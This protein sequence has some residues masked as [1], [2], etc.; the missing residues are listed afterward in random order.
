MGND[1]IRLDEDSISHMTSFLKFMPQAIPKAIARAMN[2]AISSAKTEASRTLR[3]KYTLKSSTI[4]E[5]MSLVRA[6]P[7]N[8]TAALKSSSY[9]ASLSLNRYKVNP[10]KDTT[11]SPHRSVTVEILKGK[12]FK[13]DK[14]FV[15]NGTVFRRSG[16]DRLPI[17]KQTG[18]SVPQLLNSE[19]IL[20]LIQEHVQQTF[21]KRLSHEVDALLKGD[22]KK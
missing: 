12:P 1:F 3:T 8:L 13:L 19:K 22:V 7:N 2:R 14:G 11:G 20:P 10:K 4:N 21:E 17:I 9:T 15:W 16:E 5:T 6:K 18:P